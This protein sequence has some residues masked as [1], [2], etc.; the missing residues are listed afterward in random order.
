LTKTVSE[1]Q[2][3]Y[4]EFRRGNTQNVSM[5]TDEQREQARALYLTG[6]STRQVAEQLNVGKSR[7]ATWCSDIA[8]DS[9]IAGQLRQPSQSKHW[10]SSRQAAR[11]KMER[12]FGRKLNTEEHVHH[13]NGDYT[14]NRLENLAVMDGRDHDSEHMKARLATGWKPPDNTG[15]KHTVEERR[16]IAK[17]RATLEVDSKVLKKLRD[18]GLT[19]A[20]IGRLYGTSKTVIW[21]RLKTL[22]KLE[23]ECPSQ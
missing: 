1:T 16:K 5:Y 17:N 19:L 15:R 11:K 8:R 2:L 10:R 14:D 4:Y 18:E 6:L 21:A 12:H 13:I 7:V 22:A 23:A 20:A 3:R 9:S